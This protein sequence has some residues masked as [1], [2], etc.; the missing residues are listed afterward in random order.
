MKYFGSD[1]HLDHKLMLKLGRPFSSIQEMNDVIIKNVID[2]LKPGDIFYFLGDLSWSYYQAELFF[3][4]LPKNVQFHWIL[5]NHDKQPSKYKQFVTSTSNMKEIKIQ[6][7]SVT[8][9]HYPMTTWNKSHFNSWMLHGHHH[10]SKDNKIDNYL[11]GKMLNVNVE[12]HDYK[13]LS[14]FDIIDI[15]KDKEDN[16]DLIKKE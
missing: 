9:C 15:M 10:I 3:S 2:V 8:L 11:Q 16:F 14:E 5:G 7:N 4:Q 13:P 12:F 1:F 6:E